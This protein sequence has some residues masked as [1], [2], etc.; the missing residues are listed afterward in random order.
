MGISAQI[1]L[2]DR[3]AG[4]LFIAGTGNRITLSIHSLH[5]D[6]TFTAGTSNKAP[7]GHWQLSAARKPPQIPNIFPLNP[8]SGLVAPRF[9]GGGSSFE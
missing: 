4:S 9:S 7:D 2:Q 6:I 3:A 1:G 8:R 5:K